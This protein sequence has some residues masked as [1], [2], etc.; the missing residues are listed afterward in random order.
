[1]PYPSRKYYKSWVTQ[2]MLNGFPEFYHSRTCP[3]SVANQMINYQGTLIQ[4][5]VQQLL[6]ERDNMFLSTA[7]VSLMDHLY[8]ADIP[9]GFE[10]ETNINAD[11]NLTYI[12]PTVLAKIS[13]NYTAIEQAEKNN[14]ETL[15]YDC[16]ATRLEYDNKSI[17]WQDVI[18][19]TSASDIA[20]ITPNEVV[21]EGFLYIYLE[22][23]NIWFEEFKDIRYFSKIYIKGTTRKGT[24]TTE[25]IPMRYNG[26]YKTLNQWK[27]ISSV[28]ISHLSEDAYITISCLPFMEDPVFD[29]MNL[30]V[31][32]EGE[33]RRSFFRIEDSFF[34]STLVSESY[35][36]YDEEYVR[37]GHTEKRT[38]YQIEL[39]DKDGYNVNINGFMIKPYTRYIYAIDNYKF[40]VYDRYL[41]YPDVSGMTGES[42]DTRM[43]LTLEDHDWIYIRG[44]T[45][46]VTTRIIDLYS[47]PIVFRWG[48]TDPAGNQYRVGKD[49][50]LWDINA[51][52]GWID[53]TLY[54]SNSWQE[55][56]VPFSLNESGEYV[57]ELE[58]RYVDD[59]TG[60]VFHRK[61]KLLL[62][63]PAIE[64]EVQLPLPVAL[65]NCQDLSLD[66]DNILWFYNGTSIIRA[67]LFHD[68]FVVDYERKRIW[69]NEQYNEI[70]VVK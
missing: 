11:G 68:Y 41:P 18:P 51:T 27:S 14:I 23:N 50:S 70:R 48:L 31:P 61:T 12:A 19:K 55:Q 26:I 37:R 60:E 62:Y 35:L 49:G 4:D 13:D 8:H 30:A 32:V 38:D 67:S 36:E 54:S 57:V 43:N 16:L 5:T 42:A 15:Y 59:E 22:D 33:G 29:S 40:Y 69:M 3:T 20:N 34:G 2:K 56:T 25:V 6:G 17:L 52:E 28:F 10:F 24:E 21:L 45:A 66:T 58:A 46:N 63:V 65:R 39:L 9:F 1:M 47:I 64:P 53:N 7:S 44:E